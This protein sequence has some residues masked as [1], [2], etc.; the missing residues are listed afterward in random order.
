MWV[1]SEWHSMMTSPKAQHPTHPVLV[2]LDD[3][4]IY[5]SVSRGKKKLLFFYI[6]TFK[7]PK[8]FFLQFSHISIPVSLYTNSKSHRT[9]WKKAHARVRLLLVFAQGHTCLREACGFVLKL[10]ILVSACWWLRD[11]AAQQFLLTLTETST[12]LASYQEVFSSLLSLILTSYRQ[13]TKMQK[14]NDVFDLS[15]WGDV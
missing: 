8:S 9:R 6:S 5:Y 13:K 10:S 14:Q 12:Q 3:V 15:T 7:P 2:K 1:F 11:W 4:R